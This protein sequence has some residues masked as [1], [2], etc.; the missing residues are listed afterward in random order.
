MNVI[1]AYPWDVLG[2][3]DAPA[4]LAGLGA[5]AVAL[6]A[7]YHT[8]RAATPHHP[9]H[10]LVDARH[11]ACYVPVAPDAWRGQRLVP[12]APTWLEEADPFGTARDALRAAG[13]AVHAWV[14]LTHNS[15]LGD[16]APDVAV[17][18]AFGDRYPYALCP[19]APDVAAFCRTLVREVVRQGRPDGVV[20]EACGPLGFKHGGHHEKTEGADWSPVRQALL[21]LC[22][23][24]ACA[25]AY[26]EA[27]IDPD[28]LAA[29]VRA[30]VDGPAAPATVAAVGADTAEPLAAVRTGIA[31]RLRREL[32]AEIRRLDPS[33]P[34]TLHAS[35]DPWATG[36][37]ATAAP[38]VGTAVDGLVGNCWNTPEAD[39]AGLGAL[40]RLAAGAGP[41]GTDARLGAYVLAL[42][43]RP[44]DAGLLRELID[45]YTAAGAQDLHLYHG[46]LASAERL[47]A[48]AKAL[49]GR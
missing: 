10:R 43:P 42:P 14:V 12:A 15:L 20:L 9:R 31:A 49:S 21:S 3:P 48:V 19:S 23:C 40:R 26:R 17:R 30:G 11:A 2:D 46:G 29:R 16:A 1:Y 24:A 39:V 33:V 18:N 6:A 7:N 25:A 8:V 36:P 44:A 38:E 41:G 28:G 45:C 13:L 4:R 22:F 37:F 34:V 47:A 27:G 32:V 5:G 35:A